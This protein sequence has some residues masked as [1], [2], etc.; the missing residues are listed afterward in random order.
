[1]I[2]AAVGS[3]ITGAKAMVGTSGGGFDLMTEA[4]SLT[5]MAEVPVVIYLAQRP[6]PSTGVATYTGQ[7]DLNMARHCGHGECF[8]LVIAPGEPKEA[9]ELTSQAFYFSYKFKIPSIVLGDKHLAESFYTLHKEAKITKSE[10]TTKLARFNSYEKESKTNSATEDSEII[11]KNVIERLKKRLNIK[12]EAS[13]FEMYSVY[14]DSKSKNII[15]SWGSTKGAIIDAIKN[16]NVCFLQ[17]KY[18]EPFPKEI[19]KYFERKNVILIENN[20][21]GQLGDLIAEKS[22]FFVEENNKILRFDGRPF[23]ADELE[24]KIRGRIK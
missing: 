11:E 20:S 2:N 24:K 21:T 15:V 3:A 23:L 8:R 9:E 19:K 22:G 6:G 10:S 4:V 5:G 7:G 18:L 13:K 17:I 12:K 1:M 14:G 16:L